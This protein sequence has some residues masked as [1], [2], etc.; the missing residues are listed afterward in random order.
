MISPYRLVSRGGIKIRPQRGFL[1]IKSAR[2][3]YQREEAI[4]RYVF[5]GLSRSQHSIRKSKNRIAIAFVQDLKSRRLA[6]RCVLQQPLVCFLMLQ[7][8]RSIL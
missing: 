4:V 3:L 8:K 2:F 1:R 6:I 7:S 5:R